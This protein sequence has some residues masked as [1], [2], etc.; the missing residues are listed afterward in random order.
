LQLLKVENIMI[1]GFHQ[2]IIVLFIALAASTTLWPLSRPVAAQEAKAFELRDGVIVDPGRNM[3][4]VMNTKGGID[5][6]ELAKGTNVWSTDRAAKPLALIS[7]LL[8]SQAESVDL[9]QELRIVVLNVKERVQSVFSDSI[10]LP[11]RVQVSID[12]TLNSSF[13][14]RAKALGRDVF[15][16]WEYSFHPIKGF[17]SPD[18]LATEFP[19][20]VNGTIRVDLSSRTISSLRPAEVPPGL[21]PRSPDLS[22]TERLAGVP[23]PQFI[24][25][26]SGHVLSGERI[27]DD[28]VWNRYRWRIYDLATGKR[29]A[30]ITNF[31]AY[32]PFCV[33]GSKVIF[34]TSPY[35]LRGQVEESLKIRAVNLKTGQEIWDWL[36]RDTYRGPFLPKQI[37]SRLG[38]EESTKTEVKKEIK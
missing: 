24:S 30:E 16:S 15:V 22:T 28:S 23:E 33:L 19:Q 9:Q 26:D 37:S 5:A 25:A 18:T 4:Y 34:E 35:L 1:R 36:V 17:A 29:V 3:A 21:V 2:R 8:V 7:D 13:A 10:R 31:Q 12:K 32:A 20:T 14:T 11:D 38:S 6:V 27:A